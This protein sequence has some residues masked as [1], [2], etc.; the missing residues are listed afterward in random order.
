MVH[1]GVLAK[2]RLDARGNKR[3]KSDEIDKLD[4]EAEAEAVV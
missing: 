1:L 2:R 3:G 4:P